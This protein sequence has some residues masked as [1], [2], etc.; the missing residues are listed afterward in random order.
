M[1]L[2]GGAAQINWVLAPGVL[3]TLV[4]RNSNSVPDP[5]R[6]VKS[7]EKADMRSVLIGPAPGRTFPDTFQLPPV[8]P[9]FCTGLLWKVTT[10]SSKGEITLE[11][12]QLILLIYGRG[13]HLDNEVGNRCIDRGIRQR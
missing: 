5:N 11:S 8:I 12:N 9:A 3:L 2:F 13:R 4:R 6:G 1:K 10:L 7:F